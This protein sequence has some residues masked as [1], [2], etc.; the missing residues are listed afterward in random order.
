MARRCG[1]GRSRHGATTPLPIARMIFRTFEKK[2][3]V[4]HVRDAYWITRPGG[5]LFNWHNEDN[6]ISDFNRAIAG[7]GIAFASATFGHIV[8]GYYARTV[9]LGRLG[10]SR[11]RGFY[12]DRLRRCW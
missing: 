5:A 11:V 2:V 8:G 7:M 10:F 6:F 3:A 4:K 1:G 9:R 12:P